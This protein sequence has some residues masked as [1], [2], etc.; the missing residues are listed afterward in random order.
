MTENIIVVSSGLGTNSTALLAGM[1]E[2][3]ER[4]DYITFADTEGEKPGTYKHLEAL[5]TWL[6]SVGF[7]T[8]TVVKG[9]QPAQVR[10]GSLEAE[11]LELG[12][13]PSKAYGFGTCSQ[14]W[15]IGPQD[16]FDRALAKRLGVPTSNITRLIGFDAGEP[17]RAER[18]IIFGS[19]TG[20]AQRFPLIEWGWGRAECVEAIRRAG[21]TQPGKS[22]CFF[23]PSS[24]KTEVLWLR[25]N[26][27]DLLERALVMERRA[28]AG[29]GRAPAFKGKG[30]GRHWNWEE[31]VN[32]SPAQQERISEEGMPSCDC[33][34]YDG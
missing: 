30:L 21:L 15:K 19:K 23:C 4:P 18:A 20:V 17:G 3:G 5:N 6:L 29:E 2:R 31:L 26:H 1:H 22:A 10:R 11:C 34:C 7:P 13:L 12:V 25:D 32:A 9:S 8:T 33:G 16:K 14:K 28:L 24:R 27:P